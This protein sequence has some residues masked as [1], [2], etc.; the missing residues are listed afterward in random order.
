MVHTRAGQVLGDV[1][2]H[3]ERAFGLKPWVEDTF[4][5]STDP[6]FVEEVRDI[7]ALYMYP[8]ERVVVICVDEK[9]RHEAP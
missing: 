5:L 2:A 3:G 1:P 9:V 4:K 6:Q 8:P 7:V